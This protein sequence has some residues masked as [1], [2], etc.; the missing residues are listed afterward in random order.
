MARNHFRLYEANGRS[1]VKSD[2]ML[3]KSGSK[4]KITIES[5][6]GRLGTPEERNPEYRSGL[7]LVIK[8]LT[9]EKA[10]ITD[11][12]LDTS[13]VKTQ[14]KAARRAPLDFP[15][16]LTELT[17]LQELVRDLIRFQGNNGTRRITIEFSIS[18]NILLH[19][20]RE[21]LIH[22][23]KIMNSQMNKTKENKKS[24]RTKKPI[25]HVDGNNILYHYLQKSL[26]AHDEE[27]F[28]KLTS[29]LIIDLGIWFPPL[30]YRQLPIA[31]P[32]VIRDASC[33]IRKEGDQDQWSSPNQDG[34][35]RDDNTLI[36]N[37][38]KSFSIDS[39]K[40]NQYDKHRLGKGF[41]AAH[42][43]REMNNGQLASRNASTNSFWPNLIWLP[44]NVAKL[45]DI[46][47]SFAQR[48]VQALSLKI[49]R[50]LMIHPDL[51][52]FVEESWSLLPVEHGISNHLLPDL[53]EL[54]YF[55][56]PIDFIEKKLNQIA[57]VSKGLKRISQNLE[58]ESKIL[59]TR[60]TE[61]LPKV[62][63]KTALNLSN[64]LTK[65]ANAVYSTINSDAPTTKSQ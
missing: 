6:G 30:I 64:H 41:I 8:R 62:K 3:Q 20:L 45:T 13:R 35:L 16:P 14:P 38:I 39:Q 58:L 49:Y 37:L 12:Y 2:F 34:F 26:R 59:H 9:N 27:L 53:N 42:V 5:R 52:P 31:L 18:D 11:A 4:W 40:I 1:E 48:F 24:K 32:F 46:D 28:Q 21:A 10:T 36:K 51:A 57:T 65:Y 47:G 25:K 29:R 15:I 63:Q 44:R 23:K 60:Y 55:E 19:D 61:G 50:D 56:V 7:N 17:N 43:W 33:R 54:N 22:G